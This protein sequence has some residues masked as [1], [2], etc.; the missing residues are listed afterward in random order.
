M[1]NSAMPVRVVEA[2]RL[3]VLVVVVLALVQLD[4]RREVARASCKASGD[5][6][7]GEG[8]SDDGGGGDGGGDGRGARRART[9]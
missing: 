8:G 2:R 6:G 9:D 1:S 4:G 3:L 7:D 5:V